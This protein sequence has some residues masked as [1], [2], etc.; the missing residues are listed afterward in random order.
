MSYVYV[1]KN[2]K[3][4]A[5]QRALMQYRKPKNFDLVIEA[6]RE[7]DRNDLIGF[8][9]HALIKPRSNNSNNRQ[10]RRK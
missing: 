10:K 6:L 8:D 9:K 2:P 1:A 3:E 7:A 5:M 4:K